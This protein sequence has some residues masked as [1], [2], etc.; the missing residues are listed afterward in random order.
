MQ[1]NILKKGDQ[2]ISVT[3]R[4]IAVRRKNGET[5]ILP[6]GFDE[7]GLYIEQ[8]KVIRIGYGSNSVEAEDERGVKI[9]NF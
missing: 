8:D 1:I 9:I 3:E 6:M 7:R 4:F 5:D 2:V